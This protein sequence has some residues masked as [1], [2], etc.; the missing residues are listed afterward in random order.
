MILAYWAVFIAL[1]VY[2]LCFLIALGDDSHDA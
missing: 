1:D 2:I